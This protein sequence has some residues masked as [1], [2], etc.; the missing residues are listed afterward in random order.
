VVAKLLTLKKGAGV[1]LSID[2]P[3]QL[4]G[5]APRSFSMFIDNLSMAGLLVV[6]PYA[7][8]PLLFGREFLRVTEDG[9]DSAAQALRPHPKTA[10]PQGPDT[11]AQP[12]PC[13]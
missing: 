7:L 3:R 13:N 4:P 5:L 10:G 12:I 9:V 2:A 8:L 1:S 11:A 6:M